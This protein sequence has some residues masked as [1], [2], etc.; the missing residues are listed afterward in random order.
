MADPVAVAPSGGDGAALSAG[1]EALRAAVLSGRP[2]GWHHGHGVLAREGMAAWMAAWAALAPPL[3]A[4]TTASALSNPSTP[5]TSSSHPTTPALSSL[6]NAGEI[7]DV[8]AQMA[9]AHL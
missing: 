8:L 5:T 7:V 4:G 9:L 1:Y 3:A 6:P 2:E